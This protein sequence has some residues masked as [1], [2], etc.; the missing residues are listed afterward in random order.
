[1]GDLVDKLAPGEQAVSVVRPQSAATRARPAGNHIALIAGVVL[2]GVSALPVTQ[3]ILWW[4]FGK[5][6]LG[7]AQ[8][9]PE[10]LRWLAPP[11]LWN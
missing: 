11:Q 2:G 3:F 7:A 10:A 5:D 1:M 8:A 4:G 6:P 9:L